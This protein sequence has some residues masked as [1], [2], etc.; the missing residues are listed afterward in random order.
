MRRETVSPSRA[1][2][3]PLERASTV[4]YRSLERTGSPNTRPKS[5]AV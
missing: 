1:T 3:P 4:K 2:P 5:F